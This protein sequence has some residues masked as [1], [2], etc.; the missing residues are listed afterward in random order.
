MMNKYLHGIMH[1]LDLMPSTI[2]ALICRDEQWVIEACN[3]HFKLFIQNL[4]SKHPTDK[5]NNTCQHDNYSSLLKMIELYC[6]HSLFKKIQSSKPDVP[7][8]ICLPWGKWTL[9]WKWLDDVGSTHENDRHR[10]VVLHE[11]SAKDNE[12]DVNLLYKE[13]HAIMDSMYDGMWIIDSKG[14]TLYVNRAM[15]RIANIE[16][17]EMIGKSVTIPMLEGKFSAAVT[18]EALEQ[19]KIVTRFDDYPNGTRCLNTSTPIFD[20][21]GNIWRV[22]ACI[23]DITEL[24]M[25]QRRLADAERAAQLLQA[26]AAALQHSNENKFVATGKVMRR[27]VA[28]LEKAAR[29]PSGILILGET[30]TGKTYAASYIHKK[31]PRADGPFISVNCAAIPPTLIESELFGYEKGAFTGASRSGKKGYFGLADNGTLLLDEIGELPLSMQ[32]KILHVLDGQG[33]RKIGGEKELRVDVRIIAATNRPLDQLV[34]S[35]LFRAD[36][37]YRLRVLS[38][39]MPPL[40]EHPEDIPTLITVFLDKACTRYNTIKTFSPS[41]V[42]CFSKHSWPGNVRELRAAV[43]FLAAMTESSVISMRDLPSYLLGDIPEI[44]CDDEEEESVPSQV[45]KNISFRET[46]ENLERSLIS[47]ALRDTGSTYKAAA[48]L[49]ISQSTVVRKAKQLRIPVAEKK[50]NEA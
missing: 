49:G 37:Y 28:E 8:S 5:D 30:G 41:V 38:I 9:C 44:Y 47:K 43:D 12:P 15:K 36:L 33:F 17:E 40:R 22:V 34:S 23:R 11:N 39:N 18:L 20:K 25:L 6:G 29:A 7:I 50:R 24:E 32:A 45:E 31:S 27:C 16:P 42:D 19:R 46:V 14:T 2:C 10:F 35:G 48:R 26:E 3:R 4:C 21:Q 1:T 13:L